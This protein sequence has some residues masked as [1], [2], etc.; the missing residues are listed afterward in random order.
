MSYYINK[1]LNVSFD[2]AV[3]KVTDELKKEGFIILA[4]INVKDILEKKLDIDFKEYKIIGAC[5]PNFAYRALLVEDKIGLMLLFN[6]I[7]QEISEESIE[8]AAV[9]PVSSMA[10]IANPEVLDNAKEM[11]IK[12]QTV[13]E[14]L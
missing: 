8:V 2:E 7:V 4:E 14:N 10:V 1:S 6:V 3:D 5:D 9:D 11:L 12:L 13:I